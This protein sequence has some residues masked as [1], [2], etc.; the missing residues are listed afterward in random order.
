MKGYC[1]W[2][3]NK[4]GLWVLDGKVGRSAPV[5][6][7]G[8]R[9]VPWEVSAEAWKEYA[10]QGHGD[11]S[12]ERLCERGGFGVAELAILLYDRIKRLEGGAT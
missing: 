7:H 8:E 11:Q 10:A 3:R 9:D 6:T 12:H 5:Q 2:Y 4:D 1:N